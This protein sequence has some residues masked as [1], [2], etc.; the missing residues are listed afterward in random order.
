M[1]FGCVLVCSSIPLR[2][3]YALAQRQH[4][5]RARPNPIEINAFV[6]HGVYISADTNGQHNIAQRKRYVVITLKPNMIQKTNV[7]MCASVCLR[8]QYRREMSMRRVRGSRVSTEYKYHQ[9]V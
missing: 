4:R 6:I 9:V 3:F 2:A 1:R 5:R 8:A 7:C